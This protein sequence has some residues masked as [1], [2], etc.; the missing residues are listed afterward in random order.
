MLLAHLVEL[1]IYFGM[2]FKTPADQSSKASPKLALVI[3]LLLAAVAVIIYVNN[4]KPLPV[5][6]ETA[7]QA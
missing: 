6:K 1:L 3:V 2:L 4:P 5:V 7:I